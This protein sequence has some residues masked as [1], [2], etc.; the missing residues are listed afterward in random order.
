MQNSALTI[1]RQPFLL[2]K[3]QRIAVIAAIFSHVIDA[4]LRF[5]LT[6]I[7]LS[8]LIYLRDALT[9]VIMVAALWHWIS[10]KKQ[11]PIIPVTL[12]LFA[13]LCIGVLILGSVASPIMG[14]K[15]YLPF[16]LGV[17]CFDSMQQH[18]KSL[19]RLMTAVFFLACLG[20]F[21]NWAFD[22]PWTGEMVDSAAGEVSASREWT[23]GGVR[24]L[25][26]FARDSVAA[27]TIV[28]T[29]CIPIL[30][31]SNIRFLYRLLIIA[32]S[33]TAI[34]LTT[35]K[36]SLMALV[37][38]AFFGLFFSKSNKANRLNPLFFIGPAVGIVI[39]ALVYMFDAKL[40][41]NSSL[42]ALLASFADRINI[43]WPLAFDLLKRSG[44]I[45]LGRGLG[46]IG[47]GQFFSEAAYYN[48]ADNVMVCLFISMGLASIVYI[49]ILMLR[50]REN[51]DNVS[52]YTWRCI[53]GWLIYWYIYG[54]TSNT[55][56]IPF[57]MFFAGL[58]VG[59]ALSTSSSRKSPNLRN[60]I[61]QSS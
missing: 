44:N 12:V 31:A 42:G 61:L 58:I 14:F 29:T 22:M 36:G 59:A 53:I 37:V 28:A 55:I 5:A 51:A 24:R 15:P 54:I 3:A 11:N 8:P 26:G 7:H 52:P 41:V 10:G 43:T 21:L 25:A 17:A 38:I 60:A 46:G 40:E 34:V 33:F 13:H 48:S 19:Y 30:V 4:P 45:F 47:F 20:I 16:L 9:L 23:S 1:E 6:K 49:Y 39:P 18:E 57:F 35:S 27:S 32:I 2:S 50:L 56:E